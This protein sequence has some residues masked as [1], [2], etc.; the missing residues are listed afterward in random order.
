MDMYV[1]EILKIFGIENLD[2]FITWFSESSN[3]T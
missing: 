2:N 3:E 1:S